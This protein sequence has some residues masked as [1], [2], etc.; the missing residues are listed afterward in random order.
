MHEYLVHFASTTRT[1]AA[2]TV[3]Y[4]EC[5]I[6]ALLDVGKLTFATSLCTRYV[7][8]PACAQ[9]KGGRHASCDTLCCCRSPLLLAAVVA[10]EQHQQK[11]QLA[12]NY[13]I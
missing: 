5:S 3:D 12:P 7:S 10:G 13:D 11:Q 8:G 6:F 2:V 9:M 4:G 1:T